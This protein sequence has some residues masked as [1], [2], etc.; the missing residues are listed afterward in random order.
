MSATVIGLIGKGFYLRKS[1]ST[2]NSF[3]LNKSFLSSTNRLKNAKWSLDFGNSNWN[4]SKLRTITTSKS[5]FVKIYTKTGDKGTSSLFNGERRSKVD[6]TFESLGTVDELN[7]FVGLARQYSTIPSLLDQLE[8]VSL[9]S[10]FF[11]F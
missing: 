11:F 8:T 7:S 10:C 4:A 6:P 3:G 5:N 2:F 9:Y 1:L